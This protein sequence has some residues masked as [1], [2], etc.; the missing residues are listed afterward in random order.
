MI[1]IC[2]PH[3][4]GSFDPYGGMPTGYN[5]LTPQQREI[6]AILA[7]TPNGWVKSERIAR[8]LYADRYDGGPLNTRVVIQKQIYLIRKRAPS[9]NIE[10]ETGR[11]SSG[12]RLVINKSPAIVAAEITEG[13]DA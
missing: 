13:N 3:C 9:I 5:N 7:Q 4:G 2:C 1:N 11:N 6:V 10:S 8:L 12:Y